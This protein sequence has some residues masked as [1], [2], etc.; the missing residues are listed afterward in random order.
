MTSPIEIMI[1]QA[2]GYA[3]KA[4]SCKDCG[5]TGCGCQD[6]DAY[7]K[8]IQEFVKVATSTHRVKTATAWLK[9]L[10]GA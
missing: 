4:R 7:G 5:A 3:A 10:K 6:P 1:D 9:K 8:A 2:T